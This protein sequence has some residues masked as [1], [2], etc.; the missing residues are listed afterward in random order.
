MSSS[1]RIGRFALL[2][3]LRGV[4]GSGA[5]S[6]RRLILISAAAILAALLVAGVA[7][8]GV[9]KVKVGKFCTPNGTLGGQCK[10]PRGVAVNRTG[11]GGVSP[12]DVYVVDS[13]NSRIQQFSAEGVF[14]RAFG[15]GVDETTGGDV[16]TASSG[17]TCKAGLVSAAPGAF[18][19]PLSIAIDQTTG[20][21]YVSDERN[22][23]VDVFTATGTFQGAFGWDVINGGAE[24]NGAINGTTTVSGVTTTKKAFVVGQVISGEGIPANTTITAVGAGTITLSQAATETKTVTLTAPEGAGNVPGN[25]QQVVTLGGG[26]TGGTFTLTYTTP[27]PSN[28]T[29]TTTGIAFN[30]TAAEVQTA[31]EGLAN[32]GAGN[33]AVSG[34]AG[35][36]WTVEFEGTRFADTNVTQ[37]TAGATNLTPAGGTA[38]VA[39]FR[40]GGS[41]EFCTTACQAGVAGS[42]AGQLQKLEGTGSL[43]VDPRN[44]DLYIADGGARRIDEYAIA[45]GA[46]GAVIG[47]SFVRAIGWKV[48]AAA[49]AEELQ[50][51]TSLTGCLPGEPATGGGNGQFTGTFEN[52]RSLAVDSNGYIYA[53]NLKNGTCNANNP[54]RVM[55]YNPDGTFKEVFGPSSGPCQLTYTSGTGTSEGVVDVAVD[56]V[57]ADHD[58][59]VFVSKKVGPNEYRVYEFNE[60]GGECAISPPSGPGLPVGTSAVGSHGLAVGNGGRVYANISLAN[61][62]VVFILGE[63]PSPAAELVAVSEVGTNAAKFTGQVTP[64]A[65]L[66]GQQFNTLW[67]FEYSADG[68]NWTQVTEDQSAGEVPSI[69][70]TV[71]ESVHGL[72]PCT[73]YQARVV[74]TTG[75]TVRSSAIPFTTTCT[76]P[77]I[78]QEFADPVTKTTATLGS[79]VDP[80]HQA[81]TYHLEWATQAEWE[82]TGEYGHRLPSFERSVGAGGTP[83]EVGED[84]GGLSPASLYHF[85]VVAVNS[86]GTTK[87]PDEEFETLDSCGL[88]SGRCFE[89]VSPADKGPVAEAGKTLLLGGDLRF[90]VAP[91]GSQIAYTMSE[92]LPDATAGGEV[93]YEATRGASGWSST[94]VSSPALG[95]PMTQAGSSVPGRVRG[96]NDDQSCGVVVSPSPLSADAPTAILEAGGANLYRWERGGPYQVITSLPVVNLSAAINEVSGAPL[97]PPEYAVLGMSPDCRRV[98]FRTPYHYLGVPGAGDRR[99][100]EW[101]AG[102]LRNVGQIPGPGGPAVSEAIVGSWGRATAPGS[103]EANSNTG[104]VNTVNAVSPDASGTVFGAARQIGHLPSEVGKAAVFLRRGGATAIDVSASETATPNDGGSLYQIASWKGDTRV[105]FTARYGLATNGTSAGTGSCANNVEGH[106]GSGA[107]C[108]LYEFD[109]QKHEAGEP[110]L[111]DLSVDTADPEGA[112][113]VGVLAGSAEGTYVYFAA[114]GRVGD[115]GNTYAK[116]LTAGTYNLYLSRLSSGGS[117]QTHFITVL[118]AAELTGA[119]N[120]G[121]NLVTSTVP[122]TSQVT[123][124]GRYLLFSSTANVTGYASGGA[125]MAYLYSADSGA[126]TCISCRLD[127]SPSGASANFLSLADANAGENRSHPPS[128]LS[129]DGER[130]F[131]VSEDV[132]ASGATAGLKNLYEWRRRGR[133]GYGQVALL[134]VEPPGLTAPG[135]L[136]RNKQGMYFAGASADGGDVYFDTPQRLTWEDV[137]EHFDIYDARVGGGFPE[138]AAPAAPCAAAAEGSCQQGSGASP[139]GSTPATSTFNGPGNPPV[140]SQKKHHKKKHKQSKK[141][142]HK[143]KHK[144]PEKKRNPR[145]GGAGRA[146]TDR[147]AGK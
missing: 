145:T 32:I 119:L 90:Q 108:D 134:A 35:G 26:P 57:L 61:S 38:T 54:C 10:T 29:A 131:F 81:T 22:L 36:P 69:P 123:P 17:D 51:C 9:P 55:K 45:T 16:C 93:L 112:G 12:G 99:I 4:G 3:H 111:T 21:V 113:V 124:D 42:T 73:L 23:R 39:T 135:S 31:L 96:V 115:A 86:T 120:G 66:E 68:V 125:R 11:A 72:A 98:I 106:P 34:A 130:V 41:L 76:A 87:G 83:V 137:D 103:E 136:N 94:Q 77:S 78:G 47:A 60:D 62:G 59:Q 88:P 129:S 24:G 14:I 89:L 82:A 133:S 126:T 147:R 28:T 33:V 20:A 121:E 144:N 114:R 75:P 52:P 128:S 2:A 101:D 95:A 46:G 105:F 37:M 58:N 71:S 63:A 43:T 127:G 100:Y 67:H 30:A 70:V 107:G 84:L 85:R 102:T 48:N 74:A 118:N 27:N 97:E 15:K 7:G 138:P 56:P 44:G 64:P 80:N 110:A 146:N 143:K 92:G 140:K 53:V 141:K 25:E 132:L 18:N 116:N 6:Y 104:G 91:R 1:T 117:R 139:P 49:P 13:P 5:R 142:H 122:W 109:L 8:A 50:Q 79:F 65:E 19:Q 40:E